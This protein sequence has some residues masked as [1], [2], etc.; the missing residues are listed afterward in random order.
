MISTVH[1]HIWQFQY[2]YWGNIILHSVDQYKMKN[3]YFIFIKLK[4]SIQAEVLL[5]YSQS[6]VKAPNEKSRLQK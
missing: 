1:I 6:I 2:E 3:I 5:L 4:K